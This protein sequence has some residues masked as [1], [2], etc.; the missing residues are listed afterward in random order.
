MQPLSL[1]LLV[2]AALAGPSSTPETT[3]YVG[4]AKTLD[5]DGNL[6]GSQVILLEKTHDSDAST[7]TERAVIVRPTGEVDDQTIVFTVSDDD[8]FTVSDTAGMIE[9]EGQFYGEPWAWSYFEATYRHQNGVTI[10]DENTM[11]DESVVT[12]RKVIRLPDGS[13]FMYMDVTL[14][15]I[16][17]ATFTILV[18][19]L[20]D[21]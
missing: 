18:S 12:A 21:G 3:Y 17:P 10:E 15:E 19:Q 4:E 14:K 8:S 2:I 7:V 16:T 1:V 11:A 20:T 9:G 6:T 13:V 5:A